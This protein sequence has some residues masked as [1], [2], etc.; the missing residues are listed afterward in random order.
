MDDASLTTEI[1]ALYREQKL[2]PQCARC[3]LQYLRE[4]FIH[5]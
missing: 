5:C 1:V 2:L 4:N 3:F